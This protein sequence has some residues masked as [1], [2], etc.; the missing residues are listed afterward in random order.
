M[1]TK[2]IV[3]QVLVNENKLK[4]RIPIF[5]NTGFNDKVEI[6][7]TICH[8][9]GN[10]NSYNVGDIVYV[11]FE[12]KSSSSPIVL[13]KLYLGYSE[14]AVGFNYINSL[15][16]TD[17]VKLPIDT[18]IGNIKFSKIL[19]LFKEISSYKDLLFN[20]QKT[21]DNLNLTTSL[22]GLTDTNISNLENNQVL[23]YNNITQ[24]WENH[25]LD[26]ATYP[27]IIDLTT[28]V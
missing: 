23:K 18:T 25:T 2:G 10:L 8:T 17:N 15:E 22:E 12:N 27:V 26:F 20:L 13:G 1:I 3:V 11:G 4:V 24:M 5:E 7:S 28:E 9:P 6:I 16:V 21:V 19:N 14:T